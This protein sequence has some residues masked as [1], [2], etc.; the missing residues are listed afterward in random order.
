MLY[1]ATHQCFIV[2]FVAIFLVLCGCDRHCTPLVIAD[3]NRNI[4]Q[5]IFLFRYLQIDVT[6]VQNEDFVALEK[7]IP[8]QA[9]IRTGIPALKGTNERAESLNFAMMCLAPAWCETAA[10]ACCLARKDE[11]IRAT[12]QNR[13]CV[14]LFRVSKL[15]FESNELIA[16]FIKA[17]VWLGLIV[18]A[19][20]YFLSRFRCCGYIDASL[21]AALLFLFF[22]QHPF[23]FLHF[24]PN[25]K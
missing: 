13:C 15:F 12:L 4:P 16:P 11:V 24:P 6:M 22:Q 18:L 20:F 2:Q 14:D 3:V 21:L 7:W 9:F 19:C 10:G 1:S 17:C 5:H 23:H 25:R 8:I